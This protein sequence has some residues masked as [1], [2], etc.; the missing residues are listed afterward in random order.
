MRKYFDR[1][2]RE[3]D[4]EFVKPYYKNLPLIEAF[5]VMII[6][7]RAMAEGIEIFPE[8]VNPFL[9]KTA[10]AWTWAVAPM[11]D[12]IYGALGYP[13][14]PDPAMIHRLPQ[15]NP[16]YP[17]CVWMPSLW[18]FTILYTFAYWAGLSLLTYLIGRLLGSRGCKTA[19]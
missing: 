12:R 15:G 16:V 13:F 9:V 14:C 17:L 7:A 10:E 11:V 3:L 5:V 4:R 18:S 1:L 6:I 19:P 8:S 2:F